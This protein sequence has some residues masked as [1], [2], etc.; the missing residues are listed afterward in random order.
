VHLI[1]IEH[2]KVLMLQRANTGFA[3]GWWSVPGG[4]LDEGETLPAGAAREALEELGI[5]IDAADLIFAHLC[6]HADPDGQ[7]R[8][9]VFFVATRWTGQ[10]TNAEPSK[11]SKID[12]FNLHDLPDD[13]VTYVRTGIAAYRR[14]DT[15]SLDSWPPAEDP[16]D[17]S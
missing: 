8:I 9:G 11:C 13:V 3:D 17:R 5:V 6:H 16:S 7:A 15:F 14:G 12:W 2:G 4:C 10:P 1:L